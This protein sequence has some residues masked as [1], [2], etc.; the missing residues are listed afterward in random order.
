MID[1]G[2]KRWRFAKLMG[3]RKGV[4]PAKGES[5]I[6]CQIFK[7]INVNVVIGVICNNADHANAISEEMLD[8]SLQ[9]IAK[10]SGVSASMLYYLDEEGTWRMYH[11][12]KGKIPFDRYNSSNEFKYL[13]RILFLSGFFN[14]SFSPEDAIQFYD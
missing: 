13:N 8:I 12:K 11:R 10:N 14:E 6:L 2:Y 9:M 4:R 5:M 3:L 1:S 7:A